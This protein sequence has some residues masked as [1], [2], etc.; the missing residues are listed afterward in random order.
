MRN[1]MSRAVMV[2]VLL[3]TSVVAA[4]AQEASIT[5]TVVDTSKAVVPGATVTATNVDTGIPTAT[6]SDESGRYRLQNLQP[7]NYKL[8]AE[9]TGFSTVLIPLVELRVGQNATVPFELKLADLNE[10]ITVTGEA[11]FVD[12]SS[13]QVTGN[14]NPRQMEALPLQGRNWMELSK[15]VKGMTANEVSINPGV[16]DD[17]FQLNLDGQQ[18]TQKISGG[19]GQPRFSREA[20]AEFQIVT[21]MFDITQ[22]RSAGLQVQ[23]ISRSGTN[24]LTG[25]VYGFFRDDAMNAEDPITGT[26]L[27]YENQQMGGSLGGPIIR[28]K[29]HYFASYEYEREPGTRFAQPTAMPDQSF[30]VPFKNS[31]W[32]FLGRAD[33]QLSTNDR[34]SFR[35]SYWDWSNPF[36]LATTG[37][38]SNASV[39]TKQA[40][41]VLGSWSRVIRSNLI[42]E[43]KVGYNNFQWANQGLPEVGDTFEYRFP[44]LT[45]GKPYNFPQW[46]Y[47]DYGEARYDLTW[48]RGSHDVKFGAELMAARVHALWYLQR[49]GIMTFTSVPADIS[50]R[51]PASAPYDIS[52]WDLTGLD[53]IAQRFERNY[54]NGDW[55]LEV[56]GPT[57]AIWAGDT[58]RVGSNFTVNLGVRWDVAWNAAATPDTIEN[59]IPID[60]GS[61]VATTDIPEMEAGDFGYRNDIRD[62]GNIAPRGGFTW[63]I[64]GKNDFVVRGGTGLYWALPQTQYTYSPQ[65][66]SRMI[67]ASFNNDGLPNFVEDPT[68]GV[69]TYDEAQAKAPPQA[70]RIFDPDFKNAY[71][72]QSSIGF[73]KQLG[74]VTGLE[75]DLVHYQMYNDLRTVDPNL[76]Y[77]AATG[78]NRPAAVRPNPQWGQIVYFVSTGK[79]DYTA[80]ATG[81]NRRLQHG[82]QGGVT[83]T[84]MLQMH[85]DGSASL[86]NPAANNQF[87][88]LDGEYATSTMF[89]RHTLRLW[90]LFEL[91]WGFQASGTYSFG[92]G[93]RFNATV[94]TTPFGKPGQNRLNL[95]A[96]GGAATTITVP[97]EM[98]ERWDGPMTVASGDVIPR[99]ALSGTTYQRLDLR[100]SKD[101]GL[102]GRAKIQLIGELFNVFDHNNYTAF[103]TQLSAT[104]PA[105]TVRFGQPSTASIPRQGQV[106][107]RASW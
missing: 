69:D 105:T 35:G 2:V 60:N 92:S 61:A 102:P 107:F 64:G 70:A 43:V 36:V 88:Y 63:N 27:P 104:S 40:T 49:E 84:W 16:S 65:L 17:M 26:V 39:Q 97:A 22:G 74:S 12:V 7:G 101:I 82:M 13:S 96:T 95:T 81:L 67:T 62:L 25:S 75:I 20:I 68:R 54:N 86:T 23:A 98:D 46:L 77:D 78:Y 30:T 59:S 89:Q 15:M 56:P 100:L 71:T 10:T 106:G 55:T 33:Y 1:N 91:P 32:S 50:R 4:A 6:V 94:P 21:N 31:Q 37:H 58:W 11:P 72:W 28:N 14:V 51:I 80:L 41:N 24:N 103:F 90:G 57:W 45:V 44:G 5:G 19:F 29:L 79:Q 47:Q 42:Q 18:V 9:L 76:A 99:N 38:P 52:Q 34:L 66:F 3:A 87:D 93:N 83:Y 48:N 73:Q 53:P 8:Q 85:D